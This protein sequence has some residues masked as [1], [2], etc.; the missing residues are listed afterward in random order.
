MKNLVEKTKR[1]KKLCANCIETNSFYKI[2][3]FMIPL[4]TECFQSPLPFPFK[5][6]QLFYDLT[7]DF[8]YKN[9]YSMLLELINFIF[10]PN[11]FHF[12][13]LRWKFDSESFI[14]KQS[15]IKNFKGKVFCSDTFQS[16][17]FENFW[18]NKSLTVTQ[19]HIQWIYRFFIEKSA[20]KLETCSD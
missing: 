11:S 16:F 8:D 13:S 14:L 5:L 18:N 4:F 2:W 9:E 17:L 12:P 6:Q 20:V 1:D 15:Y 19:D 3:D 7:C 10:F